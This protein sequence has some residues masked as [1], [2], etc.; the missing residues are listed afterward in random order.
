V[1]HLPFILGAYAV[2]LLL[3]GWL[4]VGA[5]LRLSRAQRRLA[6]YERQAGARQAGQG[7]ERRARAGGRERGA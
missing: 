7:R 5:A 1:T 2:T 6:A 3:A 4:S